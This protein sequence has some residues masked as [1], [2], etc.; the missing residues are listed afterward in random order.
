MSIRCRYDMLFTAEFCR[1]DTLYAIFHMI[2]DADAL[3]HAAYAIRY[4]MAC[5]A[6]ARIRRFAIISPYVS[7]KMSGA[8][9]HDAMIR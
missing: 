7:I 5:Y 9:R 4:A 8:I 6:A 3:G 1:F 2:I